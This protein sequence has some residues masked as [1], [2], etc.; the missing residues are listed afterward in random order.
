MRKLKLT[1]G[2][3]MRFFLTLCLVFS[4]VCAS[5]PA[6]ATE[7]YDGYN[8]NSN[9]ERVASPNGYLP[10]SE[11]NGNSLGISKLVNPPIFSLMHMTAS[12]LRMPATTKKV[13]LSKLTAISIL[14]L[15]LT[16]LSTALKF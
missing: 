6:S 14:L 12:T 15:N 13:V 7:P 1:A 16:S 10:T 4:I 9:L 11:V 8:Y 5:F 3:S 2:H